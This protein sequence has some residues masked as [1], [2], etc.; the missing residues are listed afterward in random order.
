M[1]QLDKP[2]LLCFFF[3]HVATVLLQTS[4]GYSTITKSGM[5]QTS[6]S[7]APTVDSLS[8]ASL[9]FPNMA[10]CS[11]ARITLRSSKQSLRHSTIIFHSKINNPKPIHVVTLLPE[12]ICVCEK[13]YCMLCFYICKIDLW[14]QAIIQHF[15]PIFRGVLCAVY[16]VLYDSFT[17]KKLLNLQ[18]LIIIIMHDRIQDSG[19]GMCEMLTA[20][21]SVLGSIFYDN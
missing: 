14:C 8:L 11:V 21:G 7:C 5:E 17:K 13:L 3:R 12:C 1:I 10:G 19:P 18:C 15:T 9:S 20:V 2:L 6:A 4:R 16:L